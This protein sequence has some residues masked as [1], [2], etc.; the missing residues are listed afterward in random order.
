[1]SEPQVSSLSRPALPRGRA[2][3]R[4]AKR[5]CAADSRKSGGA[6]LTPGESP[7]RLKGAAVSHVHAATANL[8]PGACASG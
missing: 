1:M 3:V 7:K 6:I 2:S 5:D 8:Y 4:R